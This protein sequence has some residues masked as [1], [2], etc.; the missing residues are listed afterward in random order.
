MMMF[1][2]IQSVFFAR[3]ETQ[4]KGRVLQASRCGV[5]CA[6]QCGAAT[7]FERTLSTPSKT[8]FERWLKSVLFCFLTMLVVAQAQTAATQPQ[9]AAPAQASLQLYPEGSQVLTTVEEVAQAIN[10]AS[11]EIMLATGVLRSPEIAEALRDAVVTRGVAVYILAP[12][13]NVTDSASY[14]ASLALA[15]VG[16]ALSPV[17]GSFLTIDRQTLVTGVLVSGVM[18]LPGYED[19][20]QTVLVPNPDYTAT[21]VDSF[22]QSFTAAPTFDGSSIIPVSGEYTQ[23]TDEYGRPANEQGQPIDEY[24]NPIDEFAQPTNEYD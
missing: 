2:P 6:T 3:F 9:A 17:E 5:R 22:Y 24:G 7:K 14:F 10:S 11:S 15:G 19:K 1:V 13:E 21:Y 18:G 16:V 4:Y 12:E 8:S 20:D 23:P